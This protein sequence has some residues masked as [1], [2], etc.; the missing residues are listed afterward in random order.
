[1]IFCS[2]L[3][4]IRYQQIKELALVLSDGRPELLANITTAK[5]LTHMQQVFDEIV[6]ETADTVAAGILDKSPRCFTW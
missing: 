4:Q 6:D 5:T 2:K 3:D 1:M